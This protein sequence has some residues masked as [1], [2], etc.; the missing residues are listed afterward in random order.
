MQ[1]REDHSARLRADLS[2]FI[3]TETWQRHALNRNLLLTDGVRYFADQA[4]AWWLL[5][6]VATEIFQKQA[7]QA[8]LVI[9]LDVASNK[10]GIRATDGNDVVLFRRHIHFTDAPTGH[11]R[12]YLTDNVLLLPSEY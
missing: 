1:T 8:F 11:W 7:S 12:F 9:D 5:D 4:G 10:A 6:I 3:G 2:A